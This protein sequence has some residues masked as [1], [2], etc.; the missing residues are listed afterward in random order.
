MDNSGRSLIP[1]VLGHVPTTQALASSEQA[2]VE[3]KVP[4]ASLTNIYFTGVH[5]FSAK[6]ILDRHQLQIG[7]VAWRIPAT[8]VL[9]EI[10][11]LIY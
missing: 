9:S 2:E 3:P 4:Y 7:I 10:T 11:A 1:E 8:F 5:T 6:N